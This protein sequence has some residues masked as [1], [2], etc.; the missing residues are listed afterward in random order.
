MSPK[1]AGG[2]R[3][4]AAPVRR[5]AQKAGSASEGGRKTSTSTAGSSSNSAPLTIT[6]P[7]EFRFRSDRRGEFHKMQQQKLREKEEAELAAAREVKSHP[8]P[9]FDR[10][11]VFRP[12][13]SA[14]KAPAT[15]AKP[16]HLRSVLRHEDAVS[17][18]EQEKLALEQQ[19]KAA[20]FHAKP[21]PATT[22]KPS[23]VL[24]HAPQHVPVVP[25][26]VT[27]ES[28][29]RAA[30]RREFDAMMGKKMQQLEE[31]QQ[32][33][34]KQKQQQE[35][36]QLSVLRRT[37]VEEGGLM[38]KAK[39][40]ETKDQFPTRPSVA[41]ALTAPTSPQLRTRSR[42]AMKQSRQTTY[43]TL[44]SASTSALD[45]SNAAPSVIKA[46][47]ASSTFN[48]ATP[49]AVKEAPRSASKKPVVLAAAAAAASTSFEENSNNVSAGARLTRSKATSSAPGAGGGLLGKAGRNLPAS[50]V[51]ASAAVAAPASEAAAA[52]AVVMD[53]EEERAMRNS[54]EL[55]EAL[56]AL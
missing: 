28:D 21:V 29:V 12:D 25:Q 16:F 7:K 14:S 33:I 46:Q 36:Q 2:R 44:S 48:L 11:P 10:M 39:P 52:A 4:S 13:L 45:N 5:Q 6:E 37:S 35:Q 3:A 43:N 30:K 22:Y 41:A 55:A 40:I 15:E 51:A 26:T 24:D 19:A 53:K 34:T 54:E 31:I 20:D 8:M 49:A 38:F 17:H 56:S 18:F 1:F 23:D 42:S 27:L 50:A 47:R 9:D 32:T